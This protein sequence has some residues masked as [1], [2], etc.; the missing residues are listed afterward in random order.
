MNLSGNPLGNKGVAIIFKGLAAAKSLSKIQLCDCG[1]K[2]G[3]LE[4]LP[5][6]VTE[7]ELYDYDKR[8]RQK[9]KEET[10]VTDAL[11]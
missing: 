11:A 8:E 4:P 10:E 2:A 9:E 3:T 1:W 6:G 7:S 5:D